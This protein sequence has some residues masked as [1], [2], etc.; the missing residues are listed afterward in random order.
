MEPDISPIPAAST[1]GRGTA[2]FSVGAGAYNWAIYMVNASEFFIIE[3]DSL[4][5]SQLTSGRAVVTASSFTTSSLSGNYIFHQSGIASC[6]NSPCARLNLGLINFVPGAG[7]GTFTGQLNQYDKA[8]GSVTQ[9]I[10]SGNITTYAV[11]SPSGRV[12]LSQPNSTLSFPVLYLVSPAFDGISA[13][14]AGQDSTGMYGLAEFQP[15][16]TYS[17]TSLAGNYILGTEDPRSNSVANNVGTV[18]IDGSGNVFGTE[19]RGGH[20]GLIT[21][22]IS[23]TIVLTNFDNQNGT[24]FIFSTGFIAITNGTKIFYIDT[25]SAQITVIEL[26]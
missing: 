13:F 6:N 2:T 3:T 4:N 17:S 9:P 8:M 15:N 12:A 21:G 23:G 18:I 1:T 19:D 25:S 5:S 11:S 16:V 22:T 24:G 10:T 14:V 7:S 26:Q 20:I